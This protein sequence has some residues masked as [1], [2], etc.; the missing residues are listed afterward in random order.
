MTWLSKF[1]TPGIRSHLLGA[2]GVVAVCGIVMSTI[3]GFYIRQQNQTIRAKDAVI[4]HKEAQ[5]DGL[6][7]SVASMAALRELEHRNARLLQEK[8]TLIETQSVEMSD[9]LRKLEASNAEVKEYM[10]RPIPADLRRL[11]EQK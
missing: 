2:I 4:A 1:I 11:L 10:S 8:L 3:A 6:A 7:K 5:V 9:Q